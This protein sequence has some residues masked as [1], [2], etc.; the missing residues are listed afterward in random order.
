M[1]EITTIGIDIAKLVFQLHGVDGAGDV[2]LCRRLRRGQVA[3]FFAAL[4]PCLVGME[5][6]GTA[7]FWAREIG[8]FGHDVRLMPPGYVKPYVKRN[9][10]DAADAEA[11]CEAVRRPSMRFVPVK[12]PE[13]QAALVA[14]SVRDLLVRQRTML[15]NAMRGHLAEF[16]I[17]APRG[18]HKVEELIAV[19]GDESDGRVPSSARRALRVLAT[20]IAA[21]ELRI[22]ALEAEIVA[23]TRADPVAR[24]LA[25]IPGIGPII[26][27]RITAT[28]PD[29]SVFRSGRDFAAWIGLVPRQNSTGGKARLG[30]I[31]KRGNGTLRRLLVGGAM[32]A[33]FRSKVLQNDPWLCSLRARKP[34]MVAAVALANKIAR[35][36]WAVMQH[37]ENWRPATASSSRPQEPAAVLAAVKTMPP[38]AVAFGQS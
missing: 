15:V 22:A 18:I 31:S 36:V 5:A 21:L 12:T 14:H 24:R 13:Q 7:H 4:P 30:G 25:T 34:A 29:P 6:C 23:R 2:V 37:G 19:I 28:V 17:V 16:G 27:S 26:A 35:T 3:S 32:A 38:S 9:K 10:H 11:V 20:E 1:G 33:M 8:A